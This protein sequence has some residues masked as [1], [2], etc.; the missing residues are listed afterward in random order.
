MKV[1]V[2]MKLSTNQL[3]WLITIM[4]I[5]MTALL[6]ISDAFKKSGQ[7]A[8][9]SITLAVIL[10][11]GVTY[12]A[13]KLS[14]LFPGQTFA[15]FA[16]VIAGKWFGNLLLGSYLAVWFAVGGI[17]LREYSD[18]VNMSLFSKTPTWAVMLMMIAVMLF[19]VTGGIQTLGRCSE[20]IGPFIV[21]TILLITVFLSKD[22]HLFRLTPLVPMQGLVGITQGS[23]SVFSFLGESVMVL[24]LIGFVSPGQRTIT[25]AT[26]GVAMAGILLVVMSLSICM[27]LGPVLPA[28]LIYP[29]YSVVQ[30]VSVMEF[31]Q[32][33]D[34][35]AVIVVILSIFIK[36]SLYLFITSYGTAKLFRISKW[37]RMVGV[38]AAIFFLIAMAPRNLVESQVKFPVFWK[39]FVLPIFIVG[40][41]LLLLIVGLLRKSR[42]KLSAP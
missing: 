34:V 30:Y 22:F 23:I 9:M 16:P 25:A 37:K 17:I 4:E 19:C 41:P 20:I 12:V 11:L 27:V 14:V 36:L 1:G 15:E 35:L 39:E 28:Y 6:T 13:A 3:F 5:G 21:G 8:W 2:S 32:N 33:I 29:V 42:G 38:A 24:M 31:I 18:F 40:I 10:S 7:A 26:G